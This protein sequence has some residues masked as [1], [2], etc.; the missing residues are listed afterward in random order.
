MDLLS[1][2]I[3]SYN[4]A[5]RIADCIKSLKGV[6]DEIIVVDNGSTD[7]TRQIAESLGATVFTQEWLGY[8]PQ[9]NFGIAKAKHNWVLQI[10]CDER[11]DETLRQTINNL[12]ING[13]KGAYEIPYLHNYYG[14][15][16][17][18]GLQRNDKK[19]RLW[20]RQDFIWDDKH[21]HESLQ[22][23]VGFLVTRL[24][25]YMLHYSYNS[26][27]HHIAKSNRY[28]TEGAAQLFR[29][30]KKN[31]WW[32]IWM[33]PIFTFINA[34]FFRLGLLDGWHGFVV[35]KM[36]AATTYM[37]Y[38]KL[39]ELWKNETRPTRIPKN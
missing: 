33:S 23:P 9:K 4:E 27:E 16:I 21:V 35:A 31:Y 22:V 1:A 15:F 17:Q 6:A 3:I 30:G 12:K 37:K 7:D 5:G 26:M 2:T 38:A 13:M 18:H 36:E 8:G 28:S 39:W 14:K 29:K 20:N 25:G 10:D 34:Y 11:L 19:M 24:K 32:K